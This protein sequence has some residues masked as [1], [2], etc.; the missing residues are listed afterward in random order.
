[1]IVVMGYAA[2]L[3]K[4]SG[5]KAKIIKTFVPVIN[6]LINKYLMALDFFVEFSLDEQF[7]ETILSRYRDSFELLIL[8]VKAKRCV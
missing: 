8:S 2:Q 7:N 5:I 1:M 6:Q 4:D 3:L